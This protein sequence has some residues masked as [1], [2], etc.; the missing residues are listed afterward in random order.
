VAEIIVTIANGQGPAGPPGPPGSSTPGGAI[1]KLSNGVLGGGRVLRY[2]D[3]THVGYASAD[4]V[5][6]APVLAGVSRTAVSGA[7]QS[8]ELVRLGEIDDS[9]WTW[10]P[11]L[12]IYLG[13]NGVMTQSYSAAWAFAVVIGFAVSATRIVV[14]FKDSIIQG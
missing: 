7:E 1:T 2:V 8:I 12:P 3:S 9:G 4:T 5:A 10:T 14:D 6:H 13:I 11:G